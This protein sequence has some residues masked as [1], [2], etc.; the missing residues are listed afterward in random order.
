MF[1]IRGSQA[2]GGSDRRED[3]CDDDV[4]ESHHTGDPGRNA[5]KEDP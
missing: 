2:P 3:L 4:A 5:R 1:I